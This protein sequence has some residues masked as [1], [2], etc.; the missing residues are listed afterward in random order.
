MVYETSNTPEGSP[1]RDESK[2]ET[3]KNYLVKHAPKE[4]ADFVKQNPSYQVEYIE[5]DWRLNKQ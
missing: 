4:I 5:Y 2:G 1:V 3:V